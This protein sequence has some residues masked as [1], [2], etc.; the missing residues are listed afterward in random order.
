M[1][2]HFG[3]SARLFCMSGRRSFAHSPLGL[4][5]ATSAWMATVGNLALWREFARLQLGWGFALGLALLIGAL[6]TALLMP[7]AWRA[8]LK[9][10]LIVLLLASA[11]GLH[12]MLAY[13]VL[14]DSTMLVNVARPTGARS[15]T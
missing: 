14:I 15:P 3:A 5:V 4:V 1:T 2:R 6:L 12:F 10:A 11:A 9:P 8:T 7:F 13:H